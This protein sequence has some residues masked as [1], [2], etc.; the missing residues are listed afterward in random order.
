MTRRGRAVLAVLLALCGLSCSPDV[1]AWGPV[2]LGVTTGLLVPQ[3]IDLAL[4]E[5]PSDMQ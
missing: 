4:P 5:P 3:P 2:V 1:I